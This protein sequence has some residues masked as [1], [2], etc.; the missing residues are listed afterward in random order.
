MQTLNAVT[1]R[2]SALT[3]AIDIRA[4]VIECLYHAWSLSV[5][6]AAG[7]EGDLSIQVI[8]AGEGEI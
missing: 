7:T 5:V 2:H 3:S 6:G 1:A 4:S 8:A